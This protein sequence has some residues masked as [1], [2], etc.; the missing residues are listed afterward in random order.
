[1]DRL[2]KLNGSMIAAIVLSVLLIMSVTSGATLAWFGSR[3]AASASLTMGEAIVVTVGED[4]KQ[5]E[6]ELAMNLPIPEG[7]GGL[8]PGMSVTPNIKVQLQKSNSNALLRARFITTVEY[9]QNYVDAA[10]S[11]T[12][13]YKDVL[14]DATEGPKVTAVGPVL[15]KVTTGEAPN[16]VIT[17]TENLF[18]GDMYYDYYNY[19]GQRLAGDGVTKVTQ[20]QQTAA[21]G[22][23]EKRAAGQSFDIAKIDAAH[24]KKVHLSRV[25]V[26]D[27]IVAQI[28]KEIEGTGNES[29]GWTINGVRVK[30]SEANAAE[31]EIRQR[32]VDLTDAIN[33]VLQGQGGYSIDPSTGDLIEGGIKY[34]RRVADGWAYREADQA[35]YYLGSQTNGFVIGTDPAADGT[36]GTTVG[37]GYNGNTDGETETVMKTQPVAKDITKY[38]ETQAGKLTVQT[39]VYSLLSATTNPYKTALTTQGGG[40]T[41]ISN[42]MTRNYLGGTKDD[43]SIDKVRNE[44]GV[45]NQKTIASVDLSQGDVSIDFLTKRFVLPTFINND[46]A[47]AQVRF[48]FTVEA[49]QDYLVDPLQESTAAADRLPNNLVNAILV[50][51]NAFPQTLYPHSTMDEDKVRAT[52]S[53]ANILPGGGD[54]GVTGEDTSRVSSPTWQSDNADG[55]TIVTFVNTGTTQGDRYSYGFLNPTTIGLDVADGADVKSTGKATTTLK[56]ATAYTYDLGKDGVSGGSGENADKTIT[57]YVSGF[58]VKIDEY[59]DYVADYTVVANYVRG[60]ASSLGICPYVTTYVATPNMGKETVTPAS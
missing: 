44:I 1:M 46:Y 25:K 50:F 34:T 57:C 13:K 20:A 37:A 45:M 3:D 28:G 40:A 14:A 5:G 52:G 51:N 41:A 47:Q 24:T 27:A 43:Y 49:V 58:G 60:T 12:V 6:G 11:N 59:G 21:E 23:E 31:L 29:N 48:D 33:R 15:G 16:Q 18:A 54:N 9:P 4:Y 55:T 42:D 10:Y 2:K 36:G 39:P 35:W 32:G 26:R 22:E 19:L 30:V 53:T 17:Y 7:A 8:Q 38:E 56:D